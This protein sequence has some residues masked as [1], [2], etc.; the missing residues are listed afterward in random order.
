MASQVKLIGSVPPVVIAVLVSCRVLAVDEEE[1]ALLLEEEL[2]LDEVLL[3]LDDEVLLLDDA[4]L[5]LDEELLLD[6]VLLLEE[7]LLDEMLLDE[8][9]TGGVTLLSPPPPQALSK[10]VAP[11]AI[12][13]I[14]AAAR[15]ATFIHT[16]SSHPCLLIL[17]YLWHE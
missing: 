10:S 8:L 9:E 1:D 15:F 17:C 2:L 14:C 11:V 4:L 3:L 12:T 6:E 16:P 5:L 13:A 7:L